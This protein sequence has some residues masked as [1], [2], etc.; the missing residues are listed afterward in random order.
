MNFWSLI[1]FLSLVGALCVLYLLLRWALSE[2]AKQD[3]LVTFR[4]EGEIKAFMR[5]EDCRRYVMTIENHIID[6]D[7]FDIFK[8]FLGD[9]TSPA[10]LQPMIS[11]LWTWQVQR[12]EAG[13]SENKLMEVY[14]EPGESDLVFVER[15]KNEDDQV[16]VHPR[17][18]NE[19]GSMTVSPSWFILKPD[20]YK[21]L[22]RTNSSSWFEKLFGVVWVGFPPFRVFHYRFRWIKYAQKETA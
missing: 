16:P 17:M 4:T 15:I 19:T 12:Q 18:V 2:M 13:F 22:K 1:G 5:G 9:E 14:K 20:F 10:D 21:R 8:G 7:D 11:E 3:F 6:P